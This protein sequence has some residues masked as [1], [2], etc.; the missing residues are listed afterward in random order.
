M[1]TGW[2]EAGWQAGSGGRR[3]TQGISDPRVRCLEN[4]SS[5]PSP[6]T[7]LPAA[8]DLIRRLSTFLV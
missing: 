4:D 8:D 5:A 7:G 1:V 3:V 2:P 6:G